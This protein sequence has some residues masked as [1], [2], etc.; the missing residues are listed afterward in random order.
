MRFAFCFN[1]A[2]VL[3]I[4]G[5]GSHPEI[6]VPDIEK[7]IVGRDTGEG[8]AAWKFDANEPRDITIIESK[9]KGDKAT[10]IVNINTRSAPGSFLRATANGKLRLHYEWITNE[11]TLVKVENLDFKW[12]LL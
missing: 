6:T 12:Q 11:W 2:L 7:N 10:L 9:Y 8:L 5:C 3:I 4:S 1:L